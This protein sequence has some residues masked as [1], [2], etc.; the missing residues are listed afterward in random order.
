MS[1]YSTISPTFAT[2]RI[3][4]SCNAPRAKGAADHPMSICPVM[5]WVNVLVGVP[6]ATGLMSTPDCLISLRTARFD[7]EPR[8]ENAM[9]LPAASFNDLIGESAFTYQKISRAPVTEVATGRT[10]APLA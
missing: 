8:A 4:C 6:V 9:V 1:R 5:A 10:G 2:V 7:D 3:R